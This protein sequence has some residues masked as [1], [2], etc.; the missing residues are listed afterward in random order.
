M[1]TA[2]FTISSYNYFAY[3]ET[4]MQSLEAS[5]SEWDRFTV[6]VDEYNSEYDQ[7]CSHS[8]EIITLDKLGLSNWK[9]MA[10]KYSILELNTAVKPSTFIH[11]FGKGY[12]RVIYIDPDIYVYGELTE[13]KEAFDAGYSIILTP[14]ILKSLYDD[15][16]FPTDASIL[17][18][19]VYNL[20]FIAMQKSDEA[21]QLVR[22]WQEKNENDCVED[23]AR[24]IFVDQKWIDYV[25]AWYK[26]VCILRHSGYNVAYWNIQQRKLSIIGKKYYF[27]NQELK[28]FHFSGIIIDDDSRLSKHSTR[29]INGNLGNLKEILMEYKK[30]VISNRYS[31]WRSIEYSFDKYKDGTP[32][33]KA[34]RLFYRTDM[35]TQK[36]LGEDPFEDSEKIFEDTVD[37]NSMSFRIYYDRKIREYRANKDIVIFGAGVNGKKMYDLLLG[38][39][40]GDRVRCF[41]DNNTNGSA[42]G[43]SIISP[44]EAIKRYERAIF[45]ITPRLF[46]DEIVRQLV[47]EGL[48]V[49]RIS[50]FNFEYAKLV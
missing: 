21:L 16:G 23:I 15:G 34:H 43:M 28:F 22:W 25:P 40:L 31:F 38:E 36:F 7:Y 45:I 18:Y 20:G 19:G 39:C 41:C 9:K 24:G 30:R 10:F 14:H 35:E 4:L 37:S 5:N 49:D 33:A 27:N 11:L 3:A 32:I 47:T 1:K 46:E 8:F 12:N 50:I 44:K 29:Y 6:L 17:K 48:G 2:V 13:I 26:D 42:F